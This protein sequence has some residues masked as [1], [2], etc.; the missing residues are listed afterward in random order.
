MCSAFD[1]LA[2]GG[3]A[4]DWLGKTECGY[5]DYVGTQPYRDSEGQPP[6]L[7]RRVPKLDEHTVCRGHGHA[8]GVMHGTPGNC[9]LIGC[10]HVIENDLRDAGSELNGGVFLARL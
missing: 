4:C 2:A 10:Q 1:G 9:L 5:G 3:I 6:A 7:T 8:K